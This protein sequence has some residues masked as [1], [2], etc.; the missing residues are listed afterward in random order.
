[1]ATTT[2]HDL[3]TLCGWR[4]ARDLDWRER[5]GLGSASQL[6]Q[7]RMARRDA[8]AE[9]RAA[10]ESQGLGDGGMWLD[11]LRYSAHAPAALALLPAE[12]ALAPRA[13]NPTCPGPLRPIRTGAAD[14][15]N[16]LPAEPLQQALSAFADARRGAGADGAP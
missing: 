6:R 2:T 5:L 16:R 12:D 13:N 4:A 7:E 3:P 10:C 14:C 11:A 15:R 8:V 9:L 1:M